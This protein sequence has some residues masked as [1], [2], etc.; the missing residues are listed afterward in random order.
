MT[1]M[2]TET[3]KGIVDF[4]EKSYFSVE[5]QQLPP[6]IGFMAL[7]EAVEAN[8]GRYFARLD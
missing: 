2:P 7:V 3:I 4:K 5:N 8:N 1:S 6:R